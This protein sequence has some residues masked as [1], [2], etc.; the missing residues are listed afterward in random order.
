MRLEHL[1]EECEA[2]LQEA[3]NTDEDNGRGTLSAKY[4]TE[5]WCIDLYYYKEKNLWK[6]EVCILHYEGDSQRENPNLTEYLERKLEGCVDWS[7][8]EDYWR[9]ASMDEWECHGFRDEADYN[10]WRFGN[11]RNWR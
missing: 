1:V 9:E 4:E 10:R 8:A 5:K 6:C 2:A 11:P 3:A 7:A